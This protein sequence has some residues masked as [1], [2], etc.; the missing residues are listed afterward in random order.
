MT[1]TVASQ[2]LTIEFDVTTPMNFTGIASGAKV[3]TVYQANFSS[4]VGSNKTVAVAKHQNRRLQ[5]ISFTTPDSTAGDTT[6]AGGR[7]IKLAF[8]SALAD[9][10]HTGLS[11]VG[12]GVA[13]ATDG[14]TDVLYS[15]YLSTDSSLVERPLGLAPASFWCL[16]SDASGSSPLLGTRQNPRL[17]PGT[18]I[19]EDFKVT[20]STSAVDSVNGMISLEGTADNTVYYVYVLADPAPGRTPLTNLTNLR[21]LDLNNNQVSDISPLVNNP[22]LSQGDEVYLS[23][24]P[25]SSTSRNTYIPQLRARGVSVSY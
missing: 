5:T 20:F 2:L 16:G 4:N 9:L 7:F 25:L 11:G 21:S 8:P 17:V 18:F 24:N 1:G 6:T 19:R 14:Q 3:D 23:N 10:S 12:S 15:F 13:T 22:G